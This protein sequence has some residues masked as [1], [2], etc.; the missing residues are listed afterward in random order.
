MPCIE[1]GSRIFFL[2]LNFAVVSNLTLCWQ[3]VQKKSKNL[4]EGRRPKAPKA[5]DWGAEA[6]LTPWS[7]V[8]G[9]DLGR[10]SDDGGQKGG[11]SEARQG[12][13]PRSPFWSKL[14]WSWMS[15]QDTKRPSEGP[16]PVRIQWMDLVV[17]SHSTNTMYVMGA[18]HLWQITN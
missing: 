9:Q 12:W 7:K 1:N 13:S 14:G 2:I 17:R 5:E 8:Q 4:A 15:N 6:P 18:V 11:E 3:S 10:S 16:S